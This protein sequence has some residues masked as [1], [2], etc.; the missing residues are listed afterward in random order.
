MTSASTCA[1]FVMRARGAVVWMSV[2]LVFG[3]DWTVRI[4]S[5]Q[6]GATTAEDVAASLMLPVP[7]AFVDSWKARTPGATWQRY[8]GTLEEISATSDPAPR[9][10]EPGGFW[11]AAAVDHSRGIERLVVFYG[12]RDTS[13]PACRIELVQGVARR[14][15]EAETVK[16]FHD[17]TRV[18][19]QRLGGSAMVVDV[20]GRD[21]PAPYG[22]VR[23]P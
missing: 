2:L 6:Q 20:M 1:L 19:T 11:C 21:T 3:V 9:G 5:F 12:L 17:L 13:P 7:G 4:A 8:R 22:G 14:T 10:I 15:G 23:V 16:L 18:I